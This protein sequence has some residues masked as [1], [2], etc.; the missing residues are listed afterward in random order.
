MATT[1]ISDIAPV[2][3]TSD[4]DVIQMS[5]T[6]TNPAV[7]LTLDG[8]GTVISTK[9][10]PLASGSLVLYDVGKAIDR[11]L[12]NASVATARLYVA[13]TQ[14]CSFLAVK[15]AAKL[16]LDAAAWLDSRFLTSMT[17]ERDTDTSRY[18]ILACL[19][20][21]DLEV[22]VT[23]AFLTDDNQINLYTEPFHGDVNGDIAYINVSPGEFDRPGSLVAFTVKAGNR[24]QRYRVLLNPLPHTAA[25]IFRNNFGVWETLYCCGERTTEPQFSRS[26]SLVNG[27]FD[28]YDIEETDLVTVSTGVLRHGADRLVRDLARSRSAY[29]INDDGTFGPHVIITDCSVKSSS[30]D[31][32]NPQFSFTYR[33]AHKG[34]SDLDG[35]K[36]FDLSFDDTYE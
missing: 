8:L 17:G 16:S 18:E 11:H 25:F 12:G 31:D 23:S 26:S 6:V 21:A 36:V 35:F 30:A 7:S 19:N 4:L 32:F 2:M 27:T 24:V 9:L 15:S 10:Y 1:L 34:A 29:L 13:G 5:T 33:L 22:T 20:S 14:L 3:F 28:M